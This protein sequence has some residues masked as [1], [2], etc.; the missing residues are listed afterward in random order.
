MEKLS[1][2]ENGQ[3]L[4]LSA[5]VL[6]GII[7]SISFFVGYLTVKRLRQATLAVDSAQAFYLA[8]SGIEYT[9]YN[10]LKNKNNNE[11]CPTGLANNTDKIE[12]SVQIADTSNFTEHY[13]GFVIKTTGKVKENI[14]RSLKDA[15]Y[16]IKKE[17]YLNGRYNHNLG[18]LHENDPKIIER[19]T[20][21]NLINGG[22]SIETAAINI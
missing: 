4:L 21:N 15:S 6:S 8:D 2:N 11:K 14:S 17:D 12:T 19:T 20:I 18:F 9:L 7:I 10:V 16:G 1:N 5:L 13:Y 3:V 22:C